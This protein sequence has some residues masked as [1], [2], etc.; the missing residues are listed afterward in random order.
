MNETFCEQFNDDKLAKEIRLI[1]DKSDLISS[2]LL[3]NNLCCTD[4][5]WPRPGDIL[6]FQI[7]AVDISEKKLLK[8]QYFDDIY[9]YSYKP[10]NHYKIIYVYLNQYLLKSTHEIAK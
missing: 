2:L 1:L 10:L 3:Y 4:H 9:F 7:K 8:P 6:L 5:S